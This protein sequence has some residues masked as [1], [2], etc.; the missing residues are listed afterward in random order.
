MKNIKHW[1]EQLTNSANNSKKIKSE[2]EKTDQQISDVLSEM[3]KEDY[4]RN[5]SRDFLER[6]TAEIKSLQGDVQTYRS[7]LEQ[8]VIS[9][10][11]ND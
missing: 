6:T 11:F 4:Q 2:I 3:Q 5:I 7:I 1:R 10:Q 8:K 9:V